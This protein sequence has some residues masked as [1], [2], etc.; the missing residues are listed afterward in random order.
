MGKQKLIL[1]LLFVVKLGLAQD[2]T[3]I[4]SS[5][6][7]WLTGSKENIQ[8]NLLDVVEITNPS[9]IQSDNRLVITANLKN[10]KGEFLYKNFNGEI[11]GYIHFENGK[12]AY[13]IQ[14]VNGK[15]VAISV[16][17][18]TI[19]MEKKASINPQTLGGPEASGGRR[20]PIGNNL[21]AGALYLESKPGSSNILYLD[22]DGEDITGMGYNFYNMANTGASDDAIRGIWEIV[23]AD[24]AAFDLN[25]TTSRTLYDNAD[26]TKRGW[27]IFGNN[28]LSGGAAGLSF[29]NVFGTGKASVVSTSVLGLGANCGNAAAHETGHALGLSHDGT[30]W[31]GPSA[32][33]YG[34]NSDWIPIM[35]SCYGTYITWSKGEYP[36][37]NQ[38]QDDISII[39]QHVGF[40]SDDNVLSSALILGAGDSINWQENGGIIETVN[41]VDTFTFEMTATG[42]VHLLL[43]TATDYTDLDIEAKLLNSTFSVL[44]TSNKDHSRQAEFTMNL[45][46]GKYYLLVKGGSEPAY[47]TTYS[48]FGYYEITG[49][50]ENY[51]KADYDVVVS[52]INGMNNF[53]GDFVS[54]DIELKNLGTKTISGGSVN[55]YVDGNLDTTMAV[56]SIVAQG[57]I[58][59]N[60]IKFYATGI[61]QIKAEY[62]ALQGVVEQ[63]LKNNNLLKEYNLSAGLEMNFSTDLLSYTNNSTL[64]WNVKDQS[65]ALVFSSD[66]LNAV[67]E[68]TVKKQK[69]CL[70]PGCYNFE[71]SGNFNLCS[72][73]YNAYNNGTTY[74]GGDIVA[75]QGKVYKAKWWTQK[76][77]TASDWENIGTCNG[78]T[79]FAE[80]EN[81]DESTLVYNTTSSQFSSIVTKQFCVNNTT[82]AHE[83][84]SADIKIYPNPVNDILNISASQNISKIVVTDMSGKLIHVSILSGNT[85]Q[86]NVSDYSEGIYLLQV[87]TETS[88]SNLKFIK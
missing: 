33:Y 56:S 25:V 32:E 5:I 72:T 75:Y 83:I 21:T 65:N 42:N 86:I 12:L 28:A 3:D 41:D 54:A 76:V 74:W 73:N 53:C 36:D 79:Y 55:I 77:P 87:T 11:S 18:K 84:S 9:F 69:F 40:R 80:M 68:I 4:S 34:G 29:V 10:Q 7:P 52:K 50:I 31:P 39:A 1:I 45:P 85:L 70:T 66:D 14:Q 82:S 71:L 47:F 13:Q 35:G 43:G 81:I 20:L 23:S 88:Q 26:P 17:L 48:S 16:P 6:A 57:T 64:K 27:C 59:F 49:T 2:T 62:L 78:G 30:G 24:Y 22:F 15:I 46:A 67:D 38:K 60:G 19:L 51:K 44:G 61:H 37:A 63:S 58:A 8:L